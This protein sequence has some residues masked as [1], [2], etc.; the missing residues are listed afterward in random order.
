MRGATLKIPR[1]CEVINGLYCISPIALDELPDGDALPH[2][3][4]LG[5]FLDDLVS[6]SS[7][8]SEPTHRSTQLQPPVLISD[9]LPP[10]LAKIVKRLQEGLFIEMAEISPNYLDFAEFNVG[11]QIQ[12]GKHIPEVTDIMEWVQCF[13]NYV[14]IISCSKPKR[15]ADLIGY[16]SIII[17]ASQI[18]HEY[19]WVTC[20]QCFR[21]KASASP[22]KQLLKID[23][24]T[25]NMAFP[26]RAIKGHQLQ[27]GIPNDLFNPQQPKCLARQNRSLTKRQPICF[28]WNNN[29]KGCT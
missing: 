16:Q 14:A 24:T 4:E 13:G 29:P 20:N 21:L 15:I 23:I 27:E 18:C 19:K 25:W 2:I 6:V 5:S 11:N 28:D 1:M 26:D 12:S 17:E 3:R 9:C 8:D 7:S 22:K 10:I